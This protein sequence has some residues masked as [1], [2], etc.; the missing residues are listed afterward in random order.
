MGWLDWLPCCGA[1][2]QVDDDDKDVSSV[3][4]I[5][6]CFFF[7]FKTSL[8]RHVIHASYSLPASHPPHGRMEYISKNAMEELMRLRGAD[9]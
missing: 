3:S 1:R 9:N 7:A 4:L 8:H 6:G 5:R 2:S